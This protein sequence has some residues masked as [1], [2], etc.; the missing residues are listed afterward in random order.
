MMSGD[1]RVGEW[2]VQPA[3]NRLR[4]GDQVVRLEPKVMQVLVCLAEQAGHVV[5][6]DTLIARVWPDVFVTDDVLHRAIRELRRV[7]GDDTAAPRYIETIRKRGYRL[8]ATV[9][10][11][12]DRIS[13]A[14]PP[15]LGIA[16]PV[17]GAIATPVAAVRPWRFTLAAGALV[18]ACA[19]VL[20][21]LLTRPATIATAHARFVPLVSG[22]LNESDPAIAPDGR[23]VAY[24]LR[25]GPETAHADIYIQAHGAR[26]IRFTDNPADDRMPA[27]SPDGRRL[28]FVRLTGESCDIYVRAI[29]SASEQRVA[30]CGNVHEPRVTWPRKATPCSFPTRRQVRC[31][32]GASAAS[33]S[34]RE[35]AR[36]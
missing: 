9:S 29:Q 36:H 15:G 7:F 34:R 24:V 11:G 13:E 16:A 12:P 1:F 5:S 8:I 32:A 25:D 2:E 30:P 18:V 31:T 35:S 19:A 17:A 26:A 22:P 21:T 33:R 23:R 4:R 20:F 6:R 27:W 10:T 14:S 3:V 28:A